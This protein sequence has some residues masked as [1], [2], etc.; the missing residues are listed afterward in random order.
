LNRVSETFECDDCREV[1]PSKGSMV[2]YDSFGID[3]LRVCKDCSPRWPGGPGGRGEYSNRR[4]EVPSWIRPTIHGGYES[5]IERSN[6]T[7]WILQSAQR[8]NRHIDVQELEH[9]TVEELRSFLH[10]LEYD[11]DIQERGGY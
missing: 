6:L 1:K 4:D 9:M 8:A 2:L 5:V 7:G 3:V 10:G 11:S